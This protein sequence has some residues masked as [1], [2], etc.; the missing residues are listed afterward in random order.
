[1]VYLS[2]YRV[3]LKRLLLLLAIYTLCRVG[4]YLFNLRSFSDVAW[5]QVAAAFFQGI[6]FDLNAILYINIPFIL[7]SLLPLKV[8]YTRGYQ[9]ALKIYFII[10]NLVPVFFNVAD[11]EYAKFIGKRSDS[12]IFDVKKDIVEQFGQMAADFWYLTLI[13]V[14][15]LFLFW[16]LYPP[17]VEKKHRLRPFPM[18]L[19]FLV[20]NGMV[21]LGLRGSF[22]VKPLL[23]ISAYS[24][25]S[26][27]A[28]LMLNTPFCI[29]HTLDKKPLKKLQYYNE[30]ELLDNLPEQFVK[31][32]K[33]DRIGQNIVIFILESFSPEFVGHLSHN[34]GYTPFLDSIAKNGVSFSFGFSNGRTS[35]QAVPSILAGIP[36]LMNESIIT[37]T[38]QTNAFFSLPE[39]LKKYGYHAYF[40]HGGNNG[41]MGF[42]SFTRKIGFQYFGAR[43]YPDQNDHDGSWGIYDGPYLKYCAEKLTELPGPFIAS[44]FTLSSHQPYLIPADLK[45]RFSYGKSPVENSVAYTDYALKRFFDAASRQDWFKNTLFVFTADHTHPPVEIKYNGFIYAYHIPIIFYH[46][47]MV[48]DSD[49]SRIVQQVDILPSVADFLGIFPEDMPKF[50]TSVFMKD[51]NQEAILFNSG[52]YF[53]VRPGYY[54][55]M[56]GNSIGYYSWSDEPLLPADTMSTDS[57]RLKSY[58]QYFNEGMIENSFTKEH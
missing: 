21:A 57:V 48:L 26:E 33:P 41:T 31:R 56:E 38:Y 40:F 27:T 19:I 13:A 45:G 23:P 43:E 58:R 14:V 7:L 34:K 46:P 20:F 1:M 36:Q 30:Q 5:N 2:T 6:L 44:I 22:G 11:F 10:T 15:L 35:Q 49:S 53:L 54:C 47:G 12:S 37:S 55:K 18:I 39:Y 4:F 52:R 25:S 42:D 29:L 17:Y 16:K 3:L 8:V 32:N 28:T 51:A 50:G 24:R 9:L